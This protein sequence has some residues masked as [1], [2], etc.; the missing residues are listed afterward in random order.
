MYT[1]TI[2]NI[3]IPIVDGPIS[4]SCSGGAD[5]SLL[6]YILM[7]HHKSKINIFTLAKS[8]NYGAAAISSS[9]VVNKCVSLTGNLNVSHVIEYSDVQDNDR[10]YDQH[11]KCLLSGESLFAYSGSTANPPADIAN[12]F[13]SPKLNTQQTSRNPLVKRKI[14]D[15]ESKMIKP[16]TN[17]NKK[18]I[19]ATYKVL[20]ILD[21]VFKLTRSCES[22]DEKFMYSHC[23]DC[24]WCKERKWGFGSL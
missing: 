8:L 10:L 21:T 3:E 5:S 1:I 16:F 9:N 19:A 2:N 14:I 17:F 22:Y 20:G 24:W 4:I 23:D 13:I 15:Y 6:L 11:R 18:D 12:D 7:M